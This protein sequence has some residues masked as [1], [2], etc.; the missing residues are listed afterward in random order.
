MKAVKDRFPSIGRDARFLIV[1]TDANLVT[2]SSGRDLAQPPCG[3][4]AHG[5][6]DDGIDRASNPVRLAH[7][8][9]GIFAGPRKC[10][11]RIAFLAAT[12]PARD[13]LLDKRTNI[14]ALESGSR[15]LRIGPCCFRDVVDQPV[16][17]S[18]VVTSDGRETVP[19]LR[20]VD[21]VEPVDRGT[22]RGQRVLE[23]M[24]DVGRE[25]LDIVD[26]LPQRLAHVRHGT[27]E[28][29]NLVAA[30]WQSRRGIQR[31]RA[32]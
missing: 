28:Q 9:S 11:P 2:D 27:G 6:V 7:D 3:R 22:Q 12:F 29:A 18:N 26:P 17:T 15:K 8:H 10:D 5:I 23:L 20:V 25:C 1:D 13:Q 14:D 31:R 21:P 16:E 30:P 24:S 19:K 32:E 4:K